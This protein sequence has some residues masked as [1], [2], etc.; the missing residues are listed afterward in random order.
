VNFISREQEFNIYKQ[1]F[2][3]KLTNLSNMYCRKDDHI[4]QHSSCHE[5]NF[6]NIFH[7]SP[8]MIRIKF[9]EFN[10]IQEC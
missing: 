2:S 5:G 4:Q 9:K 10:I 7:I 8:V 1:I 3:P 6:Q